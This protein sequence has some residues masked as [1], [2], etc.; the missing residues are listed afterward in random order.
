MLHSVVEMAPEK[1]AVHQ[2]GAST[3]VSHRRPSF[4]EISRQGSTSKLLVCALGIF[5]C[6]FYY[7]IVQ[8][9]M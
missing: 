5:V 7:G 8:E 2:N 4:Q 6:Y 3:T 1:V 9:K